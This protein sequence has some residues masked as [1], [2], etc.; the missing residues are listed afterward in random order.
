MKDNNDNM[1]VNT[2]ELINLVKKLLV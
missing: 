2:I 1:I